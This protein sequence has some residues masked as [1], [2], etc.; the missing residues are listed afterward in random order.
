MKF[1]IAKEKNR[2][3]MINCVLVQKIGAGFVTCASS[4]INTKVD[5]NISVMWPNEK[6]KENINKYLMC[7]VCIYCI[8]F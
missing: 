3:Y 1:L 6:Q 7:H 2:K 4:F 8:S 5:Q